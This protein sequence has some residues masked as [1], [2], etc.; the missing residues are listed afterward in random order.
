MRSSASSGLEQ[1]DL[2][3]DRQVGRPAG[4][5]GQRAGVVDALEHVGDAGR[6]EALGDAAHDRLV[7]AGHLPGAAGDLAAARP[8]GRPATHTPACSLGAG[9]PTRARARPRSTRARWPFGQLA[10]ALDPGDRADGRERAR[11]GAGHEEQA[12]VGV[13]GAVGRVPGLRRLEGE[14]HHHLREDHAALERQQRQGEGLGLGVGHARS[15]RLRPG[16]RPEAGDYTITSSPNTGAARAFPT[17]R[18]GFHRSSAT[19]GRIRAS[20]SPVGGHRGVGGVW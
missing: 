16:V 14:R 20:V 2:A 18:I 9:C 13:G 11:P 6:A 5:V 4:G 12:P 1:L 17:G 19:R 8:R 7:L 15:P 3:L 10:L